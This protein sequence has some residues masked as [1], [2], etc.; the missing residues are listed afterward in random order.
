VGLSTSEIL[1]AWERGLQQSLGERAVTLL[2]LSGDTIVNTSQLQAGLRDAALLRIR[3]RLFGDCIEGAIECNECGEQLDVKLSVADLLP[4]ESAGAPTSTAIEVGGWRIA[5]RVPTAGDL[6][7]LRGVSDLEGAI[8]QL[9]QRC[10]IEAECHGRTID[11]DDIEPAVSAALDEALATADPGGD[12]TLLVLCPSCG[13][14]NQAIF[15]SPSFLWRET[16]FLAR[17]ALLDV[18]DLACAYGWTESEIL[19]LSAARRRFY[20]EAIEA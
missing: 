2:A 1:T 16:Q 9:R 3:R 7:S 17:D 13:A 10:V 14:E 15:D 18:H 8:S 20:L 12:T 6:A 5:F 4:E 11:I 19:G